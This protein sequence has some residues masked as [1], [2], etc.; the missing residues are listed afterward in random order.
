MSETR[1]LSLVARYP[2]PT[3][4]ARNAQ[5]K[6]IF[7]GLRSLERHGLVKRYRDQ[8]RLTRRGRDELA[9]ARAIARLIRVSELAAR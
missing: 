5:S 2:H 9:M 8:Y 3:A 6:A 4:L 1:L 7:P